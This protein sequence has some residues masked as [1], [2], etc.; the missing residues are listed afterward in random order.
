VVSTRNHRC[1]LLLE[2]GVNDGEEG[3]EGREG[4]SRSI[5]YTQ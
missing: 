2:G 4:Y 1:L 3:G 5:T